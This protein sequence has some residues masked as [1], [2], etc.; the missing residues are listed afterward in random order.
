MYM[1]LSIINKK[2]YC[3]FWQCG[4]LK[5]CAVSCY[6]QKLSVGSTTG[7]FSSRTCIMC[8]YFTAC[9]SVRQIRSSQTYTDRQYDSSDL[10][11]FFVWKNELLYRAILKASHKTVPLQTR[12]VFLSLHCIHREYILF[13]PGCKMRNM[14]EM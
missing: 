8:C 6:P 2:S 9:S 7:L 14:I 11:D 13:Q 4:S 10:E 5:I 12:P 3:G 1:Q